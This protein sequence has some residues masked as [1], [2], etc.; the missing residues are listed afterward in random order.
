M[1]GSP[2]TSRFINTMKTFC[3]TFGQSHTHRIDLTTIDCDCWVEIKARSK[4]E[5]RQKAFELF[6]NK[7][8]M[9]SE[10]KSF[11][12]SYYQ[13]GCVMELNA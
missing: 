12:S 8:S 7:W 10:K 4:F 13:R 5:A 11:D 9:I 3:I 2:P 1:A 6:E